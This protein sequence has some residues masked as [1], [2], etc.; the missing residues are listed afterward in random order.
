MF[1]RNIIVN[2]NNELLRNVMRLSR[3]KRL[4]DNTVPLIQWLQ[5]TCR[6]FKI[7]PEVVVL[8][9]LLDKVSKEGEPTSVALFKSPTI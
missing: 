2:P 3:T 6:M 9:Q 4:N 1:M 7:F 8:E 5:N